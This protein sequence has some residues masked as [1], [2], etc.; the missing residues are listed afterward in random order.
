MPTVSFRSTALPPYRPTVLLLLSLAMIGCQAETG[1][2]IV[3]TGDPY[4]RGF[5]DEDFP[6]VQKLA[7]GVY[8][9]EQL[10]SAGEEKFTI[11][12]LF[13]VTDGFTHPPVRPAASLPTAKASGCVTMMTRNPCSSRSAMSSTPAVIPHGTSNSL[14]AARIV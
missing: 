7:D 10:R 8:S 3:R 1:E 9:Y 4:L 12:S 2:T 11:V 13:V 14:Q 5:T 6:Q